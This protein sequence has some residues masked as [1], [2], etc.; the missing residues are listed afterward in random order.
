MVGPTIWLYRPKGIE[1]AHLSRHCALDSSRILENL[2]LASLLGCL[3][4]P[5][6]K[7]V[8][9]RFVGPASGGLASDNLA[10]VTQKLRIRTK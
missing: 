6:L 3:N 1:K 7:S 10:E 2:Q 9:G 8:D 4:I 5:W